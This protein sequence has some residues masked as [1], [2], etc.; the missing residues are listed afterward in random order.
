MSLPARRIIA[1]S[2]AFL[3]RPVLAQVP[4]TD[5]WVASL[6]LHA[7]TVHVGVPV[8]VTH[9]PGYDNQPAFL[10]DGSGFLFSAAGPNEP[11]DVWRWDAASGALSRVTST[12]ESEYSPTPFDAPARGFCAVRVEADSTQR[13]WAFDLEGGDART[14]MAEVDSVGYFEWLDPSTVAVFVVGDPHT[15]RVVDVAS[16]RETIVARDIGRFI[17]R[18]PGTRDVTFTQRTNDDRYPFFVLPFGAHAAEPLIGPPGE[19]QDAAWVG[20]TLLATTPTAIYASRPFRG[21]RWTRV[22]DLGAWGLDGVTRIAV[23]PDARSIAIVA[24]E[25]SGGP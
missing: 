2:I 19:G 9:R 13:L 24:A 21:T 25:P 20:D 8:N 4:S 15:L 7:G 10:P 11:T 17:R 1:V 18:V 16:E 14:V 22:A 23:S 3:A 12:P 6:A 5:I